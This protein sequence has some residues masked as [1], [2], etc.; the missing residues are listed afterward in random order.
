MSKTKVTK[1]I[2][3]GIVQGVGFRPTIYRVAKMMNA[4]GYVLNKGSEVE[5]IIDVNPDHFIHQVKNHLPTIS[6]IES[7]E[8]QHTLQDIQPFQIIKSE[9]GTHQSLIPTDTAICDDCLKELNDKNNRRYFYPFINCTV[10]GA[11]YS[12]ITNVPYDR[13]HTSMNRFS[14]CCECEHDYSDVN[15]RRF[16]A[17]TISCSSCGPNYSLYNDEKRKI[18][19]ENPI[20]EFSQRIDEGFIGVIK[21]WGGMHLCCRLD[22]I[23]RFRRWYHRPQ[24][25]FAIMVRSINYI[26][27]YATIS[28]QEKK[29]LT[30]KARPIVLVKKQNL[31]EISPGLNSVG[32]FLPYSAVHHILFSYLHTDAV[33]MT[34]ANIPGEPM[35]IKNNE[36]FTLNAD[37]YLLHNRDIPNRT[38]DT[39]LKTWKN[40]TFFLRKSR[41][42][43]PDSID[44]D[45]NSQ[46]IS[47]G[48]GQNVYGALSSN[49]K[50]FLTPYLGDDSS[51]ETLEFLKKTLLHFV[52]LLIDNESIDAVV[53]DKHPS[54]QTRKI[55][56]YFSEKY[57]T[58]LFEVQH[59]WAHAASLLV[60]NQVDEGVVLTLDGVGYGEDGTMWGGEIL[61]VDFESYKRVG[62][63]KSIRLLGGDKA[64]QDPRRLVYAIFKS[65]G[66]E[67]FF[68][69][70]QSSIFNKIIDSAPLSSSMGRILDALACYLDICCKRTY[71]G[72]PAMKLERYL[73]RGKPSYTFDVSIKNGVIDTIDLFRQLHE[74]NFVPYDEKQRADIIFS[75]VQSIIKGMGK[76]AI[77][78]ADRHQIKNIGLTGGVSYNL[79]I[80]DMVY[81]E[82]NKAGFSFLVHN[83]IPNGDGGIAIGQNVI[84]NYLLNNE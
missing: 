51:Y 22:E 11:R 71:D 75:F 76:I 29:L 81:N 73:E 30:S 23:N 49:K 61:Q 59:H 69:N 35:I 9:N 12:L 63:L 26:S 84:G 54:Y 5:V 6:S 25:P 17:Q 1:I 4:K 56:Y 15:N 13:K 43:I 36:V 42:Y 21:S 34:S 72:E 14:L 52:D 62:H 44:V 70:I 7:V 40:H 2:F 50:L 74:L 46:I 10:C 80:T 68:N 78:Y 55:A 60:D 38:D 45:Y 18:S 20:K 41:G 79:P 66:E 67:L 57:D 28:D 47:V 77:E 48:A 3:K 19:T 8:I 53:M 82:I 39:V 83:R 65:F 24:K 33:I 27:D 64:T 16:H 32:L 58:D 37:Y 31:E